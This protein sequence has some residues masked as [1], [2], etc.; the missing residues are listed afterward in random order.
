MALTRRGF[1]ITHVYFPL[2]MGLFGMLVSKFQM[3]HFNTKDFFV[4]Y[5]L[6]C[7]TVLVIR[8]QGKFSGPVN[9][10]VC[11]T[12]KKRM[13]KVGVYASPDSVEII[14]TKE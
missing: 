3:G 4:P 13:R 9:S 11:L 6:S 1:L 8:L 12:P 7:L 14:K 10:P 2:L 5:L